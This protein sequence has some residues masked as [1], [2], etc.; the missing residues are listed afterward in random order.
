MGPRKESEIIFLDT[1]ILVWL[2]Q[3][4]LD[5]LSE[6]AR[7]AIDDHAVVVSPVVLL[8]LD[9]LHE[10]GRIRAS[11]KKIVSYLEGAIGLRVDDCQLQELIEIAAKETWTRDP[12]DRLI[13]SHAKMRKATLITAD[14]Q[15]AAHYDRVIS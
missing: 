1:H 10:N 5:L 4:S 8:E 13:A 6:K 14:K 2:Y 11:S 12:F 7:N 9:Y 15:M 3:N